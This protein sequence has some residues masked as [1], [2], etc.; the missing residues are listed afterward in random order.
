MNKYLACLTLLVLVTL[1]VFSQEKP[2]SADEVFQKTIDKL[3]SL[4]TVSYN[5]RGELNYAS[6]KYFHERFATA[7][8]DFASLDKTIGVNFQFVDGNWMS[9]FNGTEY[10]SRNTKTKI[11]RINNKKLRY[12]FEVSPYLGNSLVSLK[13]NLPK[14]LA[15][16]TI[17]RSVSETKINGRDF[18]VL[19]YV[20]DKFYMD[21]FGEFSK[22]KLSR[23]ITYRVT[24]SKDNFMPV[25]ILQKNGDVDFIKTSFTNIVENPAPPA[26]ASWY[27]S[28]Y[29][30]EYKFEEPP[31]DKLIKVGAYS[32]DVSLTSFSKEP[33][34]TTLRD[35]RG[36]V[37]MLQFW[38]FHCGYCQSAVP[39]LNAIHEKYKDKKFRLVGVNIYDSPELLDLFIQSK[40]P[41]YPIMQKG[42]D[43]ANE[44]GVDRYPMI[45]LLDKNNIVIYAG[46]LD[47]AKITALIDK[48]L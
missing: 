41:I 7:Y 11:I 15:D 44:Y 47:P 9:T 37:V 26:E 46:P 1:P 45:V 36:S 17:S 18:F 27:Y 24:V 48:N 2:P 25:E 14:I 29:L 6:E 3:N 28:T 10:F 21:L 43:A 12:E 38:I 19:E 23:I 22:Q 16:P 35:L 42:E 20:L 31:T 5:Y 30:N 39:A 4:K 32:R 33:S 34:T 8:L 40:K 13:I